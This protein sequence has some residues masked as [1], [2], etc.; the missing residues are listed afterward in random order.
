M[1]HNSILTAKRRK[2]DHQDLERVA[3]RS[4]ARVVFLE[5]LEKEADLID[6]GKHSLID[7]TLRLLTSEKDRRLENLARTLRNKELEYERCRDASTEQA[8]RQWAVSNSLEAL[9]SVADPLPP[10]QDEKESL[11][12]TLYFENHN[13]LKQLINEEKTFPFRATPA[14][15]MISPPKLI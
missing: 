8:W 3:A 10:S 5:Q 11:R 9:I 1:T 15:K 6:D 13:S 14:H 7:S 2:M 4:A 12:S